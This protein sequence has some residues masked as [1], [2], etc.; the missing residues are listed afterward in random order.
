MIMT[1]LTF[2]LKEGSVEALVDIYRRHHILETA[3]TVEGCLK[4]AL[5][6][7][8]PGSSKVTVVGFWHDRAAYQRW[9]DH[10]YRDTAEEEFD[11]L[12]AED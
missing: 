6:E 7:G 1:S 3:M 11:A 2:A 12:M 8:L 5:V 10:P 4:L 9:L